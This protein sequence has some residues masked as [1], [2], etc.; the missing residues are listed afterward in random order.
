MARSHGGGEFAPE[1][2][3]RLG[4]RVIFE[5]GVLV[6]HP[7]N[8][9]IGDDVYVGH[10][11]I[12]KGYYRNRMII[13]EGTWIGQQCFLHSGGG[14]TIGRQVGIGPGVKIVTSAHRLDQ[15]DKP[16]LHSEIDFAPVVVGDGADIGV[17]AVLLPGVV[18]GA[19]A[20]VGAGAVVAENVPDYAVVAGVPARLIRMRK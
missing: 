9:E 15:L 13:G 1:Q 5:T 6:F 4:Q 20:Q 16:I 11:A 10:Q 14:I 17:A 7:E 12:L 18:V 2:F 8:I 19:F 3:A